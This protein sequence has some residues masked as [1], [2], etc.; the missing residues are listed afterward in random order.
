MLVSLF[1]YLLQIYSSKT[2]SLHYGAYFHILERIRQ[3]MH[4][5]GPN[6]WLVNL[7]LRHENAPSHTARYCQQCF[8][9]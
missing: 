9:V 4:E 8:Q 3:H 7:Y 1:W 2:A 5:K 6:P